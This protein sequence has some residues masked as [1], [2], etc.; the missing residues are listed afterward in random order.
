MDPASLVT[1]CIGTVAGIAQLTAQINSLTSG[2]A[3]AKRDLGHVSRELVSIGVCLETLREAPFKDD[4]PPSLL[5]K[6]V[7]VVK[8]C[9][10]VCSDIAEPT[11]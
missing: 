10:T 2:F 8:N 4:L 9:E 7:A 11:R 6:L 5:R 3:D 1:A